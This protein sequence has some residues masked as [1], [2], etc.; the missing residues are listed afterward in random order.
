MIIDS[1]AF[2]DSQDQMDKT[3]AEIKRMRLYTE[4]VLYSARIV[5]CFIKQ[6]LFC[7]N[8]REGDYEKAALGALLSKDCTACRDSHRQRHRLSL[9]GSLAHRYHLCN[10]YEQCLSEHLKTVNRRRNVGAGHSVVSD[11]EPGPPDEAR[12]KLIK[13]GLTLG[14]ELLHMLHHIADIEQKMTDELQVMHRE[15]KLV[16][17]E[18]DA[19]LVNR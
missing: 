7:T 11:F 1:V 4:H 8:F 3:A 2:A 19:I 17:S 16:A 12:R 9:L 5:E 18:S 10:E 15:G 6:L 14:E 13:D